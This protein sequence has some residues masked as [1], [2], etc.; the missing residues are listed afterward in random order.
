[1]NRKQL[2]VSSGRNALSLYLKEI[3]KIPLLTAE[4]ELKYSELAAKGDAE[5]KKKLV[6]ANLRFVVNVAKKYQNQGLPLTDLISEGNIGLMS[7]VDRFDPQKGF[8]FISYAVWWIK[9][10]IL[11]AICEKARA[12][13]L[14]SNRA[15][16]LIQIE[17]AKRNSEL[18]GTS[19]SGSQKELKEIAEVLGYDEKSIY[20]I[21]NAARTPISLNTAIDDDSD[22]VVGDFLEDELY[23]KPE[24][25]AVN[26][27]LK[28]EINS[29]LKKLNK[30]EAEILKY[31]FGLD[32]YDRHSLKE[33]G[34]IFNL[35]KERIRQIEKKSLEH[36]K[37]QKGIYKLK[38]YVA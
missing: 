20:R 38:T 12:I 36:L 15:N 14:P 11:K 27:V 23:E 28:D 26:S 8:R 10:S 9:Q 35:T 17:R 2:P 31:R 18:Y 37:N 32:G 34:M 16:E 1:M 25:F 6:N 21:M 33:V 4:E 29:L 3:N 30:R 19:S 7:A 5:A 13:R 24:D 22:S